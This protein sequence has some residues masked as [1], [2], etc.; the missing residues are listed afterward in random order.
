MEI[1]PC[2]EWNKGHA[3]EYLLKN[4]GL[5]NSSDVFPLYMGD[6]RTDEDAFKVLVYSLN[7]EVLLSN[8]F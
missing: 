2:I 3:L 5:S 1:R 6:D 8:L 4:L 7:H